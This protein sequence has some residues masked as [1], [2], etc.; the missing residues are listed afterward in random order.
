MPKKTKE[1]EDSNEFIIIETIVDDDTI[2]PED[3]EEATKVYF[4]T[5]EEEAAL[6]NFRVNMFNRGKLPL[7]PIIDD[8]Y[9]FFRIAIRELK[10][11]LTPLCVV[12]KYPNGDIVPIP[13]SSFEI[14]EVEIIYD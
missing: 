2:H 12:R 1:S 7:V 6:L 9:D 10:E 8:D 14:D 4:M 11:R 13:V 3:I 5:K